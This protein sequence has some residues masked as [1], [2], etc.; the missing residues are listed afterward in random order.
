MKHSDSIASLAAALVKVQGELRAIGKDSVNPH[1]KS[2]YASLDAIVEDVR[3]ILHKHGLAIAQGA[4]TPITDEAGRVAGFAVETMLIHASGEW[5]TNTAIVP[6][7]KADP[8][9]AGGALTYGRRYG[10]SALLSL[11][12]E[13]D[14]DANAV[15]HPPRA[16]EATA[17]RTPAPET[18]VPAA[19][20]DEPPCPKCG[21]RMW[22]NR[23]SK[24]NPKAPDFACRTKSCDGVIWPPKG[25]RQP[26]PPDDDD[27]PWEG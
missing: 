11:A 23:L 22:D 15:S 6:I 10:L 20:N 13:E 9:G 4:T 12:T 1:F 2:R 25:A 16:V 24:K 8:Q 27:R 17:P 21:G 26:V 3:P 5:L 14:D 7:V 19:T 18:R